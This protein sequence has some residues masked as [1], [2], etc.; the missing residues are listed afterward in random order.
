MYSP[1]MTQTPTC[2]P[3]RQKG[4]IPRLKLLLVKRYTNTELQ[5]YF[6]RTKNVLDL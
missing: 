3:A 1:S 2:T 4:R 6:E 5:S